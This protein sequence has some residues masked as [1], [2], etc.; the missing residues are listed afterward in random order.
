MKK[1]ILFMIVFMLVSAHFIALFTIV[2]H[3]ECHV[4]YC[5]ECLYLAKLYDGSQY[6]D[7]VANAAALVFPAADCEITNGLRDA[8][9]SNLVGLKTRMN[10]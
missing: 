8:L 2:T 1:L 5:V 6:G 9:A 4:E 10:N 7:A 3:A